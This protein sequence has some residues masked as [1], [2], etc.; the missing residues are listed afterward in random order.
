MKDER[1]I[2]MLCNDGGE[3]QRVREYLLAKEYILAIESDGKRFF[4][5][6]ANREEK[7]KFKEANKKDPNSKN[8][9]DL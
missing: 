3:R 4:G 7:E 8:K 9:L 6:F 2:W 1:Y 5:K